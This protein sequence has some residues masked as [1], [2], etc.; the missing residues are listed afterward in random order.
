MAVSCGVFRPGVFKNQKKKKITK[1]HCCSLYQLDT[2]VG[3]DSR[4]DTNAWVAGKKNTHSKLAN[5]CLCC[6]KRSLA[7]TEN[8]WNVYEFE[9]IF[10][11]SRWL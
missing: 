9:C 4:V 7:F 3:V 5:I 8:K 11:N 6:L 1:M 10:F 2:I